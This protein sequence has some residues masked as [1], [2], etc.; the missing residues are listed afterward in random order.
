VDL[1]APSQK[2]IGNFNNQKQERKKKERPSQQSNILKQSK[3]KEN[4]QT[5]EKDKKPIWDKIDSVLNFTKLVNN[6]HG[7]FSK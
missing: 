1:P 2:D 5:K 4:K 7:F 3:T 6:K